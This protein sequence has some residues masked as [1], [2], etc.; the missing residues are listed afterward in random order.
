MMPRKILIIDDHPG[1]EIGGT[2][3]LIL[4]KE[5][6]YSSE[7]IDN[8]IPAVQRASLT[9]PDLIIP[10]ISSAGKKIETEFSRL[11][12]GA[13]ETPLLPIIDPINVRL[14]FWDLSLRSCDFL[15]TPL[16]ESELVTRVQRTV[17]RKELP[18]ALS[19]H[20]IASPFGLDQ[21]LG[22]APLFVS[23]KKKIPQVARSEATV[24]ITGETGTGKEIFAR[25]LH[26]MS[27]RAGNPFLPV[28][29]GAI[30]V[31]LF[32]R[33]LFGHQK[34]A[35]TSASEAQPGL[36]KE[37]EGGTLFLDEVE[38]L[39]PGSQIKLLRFLQDQTY[40]CLGSSKLQQANVWIIASTN[41]DLR[42]K[43][44][45]GLFREDFFYRLAVLTITLPPLRE[46]RSDIPLLASHFLDQYRDNDCQPQLAPETIESL[47]RYS[48]PGNVR[49]L[50]NVVRQM[51]AL[52][53]T[54][55]IRIEDLPIQFQ[56][57]RPQLQNETFKQMKARVI[58]EFE[59][60]YISE[61]LDLHNGNVTHA[62]RA[63]RKERRTFGRL[64][65]KYNLKHYSGK[66]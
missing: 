39:S 37:A 62:A 24:L 32:E 20:E 3:Q 59:K 13:S 23:V 21:I 47:C 25:A 19:K 34:G 9:Q 44:Q 64:I 17:S 45:E 40:H 8:W 48:W 51:V 60:S 66:R 31:D 22:E 36:I 65:K 4:N 53:E 16:R 27:R 28:N 50:D 49:E 57:P 14:P 29:C 18:P 58:Q 33:E 61:M 42:T 46:R 55:T 7:L 52:N 56:E 26:Y 11:C 41:V 10:V 5:N 35:Y 6:S 54:D 43:V 15:M 63:A 12:K 38:T 1:Q 30:P 2:V